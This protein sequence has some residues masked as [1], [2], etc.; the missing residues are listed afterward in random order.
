MVDIAR[1]EYIRGIVAR[2]IA[3]APKAE[4]L[5]ETRQKLLTDTAAEFD[6]QADKKKA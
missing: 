3:V 5:W 6:R 1:G 2:T 4:P